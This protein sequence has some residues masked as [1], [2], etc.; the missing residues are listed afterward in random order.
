M[1]PIDIRI[2]RSTK[3]NPAVCTDCLPPM[4]KKPAGLIHITKQRFR[5][6]SSKL[7]P[8]RLADAT[9]GEHPPLL[10]RL[11]RRSSTATANPQLTHPRRWY[12]RLRHWYFLPTSRDGRM[13]NVES[14]GT[15]QKNR[16][17]GFPF[18]SHHTSI[19]RLTWLH[20]G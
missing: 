14:C 3:G 5:S 16:F 18:N 6:T 8:T 13:R 2:T 4:K 7:I 11:Q 1:G 12:T 17:D 19:D 15:H 9:A 20:R 10:L